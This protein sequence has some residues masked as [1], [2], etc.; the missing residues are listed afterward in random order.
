MFITASPT[1][2]HRFVILF[3]CYDAAEMFSAK[4]AIA[5]LPFRNCL[6]FVTDVAN[7]YRSIKFDAFTSLIQFVRHIAPPPKSPR[8]KAGD[9]LNFQDYAFG[10]CH[11]GVAT[12]AV[13]AGSGPAGA[14]GAAGA[15]GGA[16]GAGAAVLAR[17][18]ASL[19]TSWS[20]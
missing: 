14:A 15:A 9:K 6:C 12:C 4:I 17:R 5:L 18:S 20:L 1:G 7:C 19:R 13:V 2:Q 10:C 3:D 8:H 16:A 11:G